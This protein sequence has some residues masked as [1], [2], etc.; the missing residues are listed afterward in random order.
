MFALWGSAFP[1]LGQVIYLPIPLGSIEATFTDSEILLKRGGQ[2][3]RIDVPRLVRGIDCA[4]PYGPDGSVCKGPSTSPCPACVYIRFGPVAWDENHQRLYFAITTSLSWS[5]PYQILAYSLVTRRV[6]RIVNTW[7]G[8]FS[9]GTVSRSGQYLAY[10][11]L[12][13]QSP[14]AGCNRG[15]TGIEIVD[16]WA[17]TA[18][19]PRLDRPKLE[20]VFRVDN[21]EWSGP[22]TLVATV[23]RHQSDCEEDPAEKPT[24]HVVDVKS[25]QFQ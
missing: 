3:W 16:L 2:Q 18:G 15:Q 8:G 25:I 23:K 6:S 22:S 10:L 12:L 9:F 20:G 7:T 11:S 1:T 5:K 14:A 13:H 4:M 21:L 24:L 17:G 19:G